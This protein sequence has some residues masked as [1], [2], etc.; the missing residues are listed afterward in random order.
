[1]NGEQL[2]TKR[3]RRYVPWGNAERH[4]HDTMRAGTWR[5]TYCY[6]DGA[7]RYSYDVQPDT[8]SFLAARELAAAAMERAIADAA[9]A[10][11]S[12][13]GITPYTKAQLVLIEQF[14]ADMAAVGGLVPSYW[15]HSTPREIAMAGIDAV[16]EFAQG[17]R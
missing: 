4:D 14:R 11:P 12:M 17:G 15:Q 7:Y 5:L 8:A 9:V 16:R 6:G 10:S 3:G 2:F 13:G 1:M